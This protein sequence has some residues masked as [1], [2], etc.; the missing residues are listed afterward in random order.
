MFETYI[1]QYTQKVQRSAKNI[2]ET[3]KTCKL[4]LSLPTPKNHKTRKTKRTPNKSSP[5]T[6]TPP[7]TLE[8]PQKPHRSEPRRLGEG[9]RRPWV[10]GDAEPS[11]DGWVQRLGLQRKSLPGLWIPPTRSYLVDLFCLILGAFRFCWMVFVRFFFFF[12]PHFF[13]F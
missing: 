7:K 12:S 11:L 6:P 10:N 3:Q 1:I 13:V 2:T 8:D 5:P 4:R 9:G